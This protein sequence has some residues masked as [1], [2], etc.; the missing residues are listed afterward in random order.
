M[1]KIIDRGSS[2]FK[3]GV[4][5]TLESAVQL[6]MFPLSQNNFVYILKKYDDNNLIQDL[7]TPKQWHHTCIGMEGRSNTVYGVLV[8]EL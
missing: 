8:K 4:Y 6:W 3:F 5:P 7:V 2:F 1:L